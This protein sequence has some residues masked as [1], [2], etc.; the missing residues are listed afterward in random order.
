MKWSIVFALLLPA[1][2]CGSGTATSS[3][4]GALVVTVTA[5]PTCPVLPSSGPACSPRPVKG[6]QLQ[7]KGPSDATLVTDAAGEAR[8]DSLAAGVYRLVPQPVAGLMSTPAP[9]QLT[10]TA[11]ETAHAV[12]IYDTGIR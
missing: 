9:T 2:G 3:P 7:L 12:V 11:G 4:T 10:V 8:G 5:G 6:A 1:F